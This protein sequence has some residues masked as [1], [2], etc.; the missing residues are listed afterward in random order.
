MK[1]LRTLQLIADVARRGSIRGTAEN[2]NITAS[3]LTR[4]IQDFEEELGTL[5]FERLPQ[6][7][8]LNAAGELLVRH[9]RDQTA[10]F[11]RLKSQIADLSGVRRGHVAIVSSQAFVDKVLPMQIADYRERYPQVSF[12]VQVRDHSLGIA[13]LT[14]FEAD[15]ALLVNPPPATDMQVLFAS[16]QPFFAL[17]R[18]DH[19]LAG[20]SPIRLRDCSAY[21]IAM[22]DKGLAIRHMLDVAHA[23][24][25]A[26]HNISIE[27]G[28]LEFLRNYI[29]RERAI[30]FQILRGDP[31]DRTCARPIDPRD[32]PS[33]QIVLGQLRSRTLSVAAA[34]FADQL[35]NNLSNT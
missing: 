22:P 19:P 27:S 6:G 14:N 18:A 21:P 9:I 30:T 13:A 25:R 7:M 23:R 24:I 1:H 4:K 35:I 2:L 34:K 8:R 11:E 20:T 3:A 17:M 12:S 26:E 28:S 16:D 15:L 33:I 29:L 5:I 31:D 10:D 32:I